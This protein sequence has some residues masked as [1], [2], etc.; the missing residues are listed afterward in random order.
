MNVQ[1]LFLISAA[2]AVLLLSGCPE[3]DNGS[4]SEAGTTNGSDKKIEYELVFK[5]GN[6]EPAFAETVSARNHAV[7][8]EEPVRDGFRFTGWYLSGEHSTLFTEDLVIESDMVFDAG[9]EPLPGTRETFRAGE[10][11]FDLAFV[12]ACSLFPAG[13]DDRQRFSVDNCFQI[14]DTEISWGL[15]QFVYDWAVSGTR[16]AGAGKYTFSSAGKAGLLGREGPNNESR[17][18]QPVTGLRFEDAVIWC[19]AL[20]EMMNSLSGSS[21]ETVYN[22]DG[23]P[24]RSFREA[25]KAGIFPSNGFRLPSAGEWELAARWCDNDLNA[26]DGFSLPFFTKG[27]SASGAINGIDDFY[28]VRR[29]AWDY[30]S[31]RSGDTHII[32]TSGYHDAAVPKTGFANDLYLY[33]MSGNASEWVWSEEANAGVRKGGSV[34]ESDFDFVRIGATDSDDA[35]D[36]RVSGFRIARNPDF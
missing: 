10:M 11:E 21:M 17:F 4:E 31:D 24:V 33:D 7:L 34:L 23:A 36:L 18:Y 26:V 12:P 20:T 35:K 19:N 29:L 16:G 14:S 8:P 6:G 5:P 2:F 30:R 13:L 27:N 25:D 1:R 15:W 32:G 9:W 3:L 28:A 22:Y